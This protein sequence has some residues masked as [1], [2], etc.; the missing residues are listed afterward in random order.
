MDLLIRS[1]IEGD[2]VILSLEGR[3]W[4]L[5]LS[6]RDRVHGLLQQGYRFFIFDLSGLGYV[7]SSGLGQMVALWTSVRTRDGNVCVVRP[8]LRI[9][10][11]LKITRLHVIFDVFED[12][13][14][15]KTS[16]HR[17]A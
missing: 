8:S 17:G 6:L 11:L 14:K 13:E 7:D 4:V 5:D 9:Q 2:T 10:R 3:L 12:L 1:Q 16:I 15:A